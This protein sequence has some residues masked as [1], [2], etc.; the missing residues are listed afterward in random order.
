MKPETEGY[1]HKARQCLHEAQE[2]VTIGLDEAAEAVYLTAFHAAQAFIFEG[3][4]K[5]AKTHNGVRSEFGRLVR[6]EPR[7]DRIYT[8]LCACHWPR[9]SSRG[10]RN[11]YA[12]HRVRGGDSRMTYATTLRFP[13][14]SI[15]S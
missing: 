1:L 11:R 10:H 3:T 5:I 9:R 4:G 8:V 15:T 12:L 6:E 2:V 13:V 7:I 14:D